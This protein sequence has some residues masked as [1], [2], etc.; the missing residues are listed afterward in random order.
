[1]PSKPVSPPP[2]VQPLQPPKLNQDTLKSLLKEHLTSLLTRGAS[3]INAHRSILNAPSLDV[4]QQLRTE[5]KLSEE[6][7]SKL[8]ELIPTQQIKTNQTSPLIFYQRSTLGLTVTPVDLCSQRN[9]QTVSLEKMA[10]QRTNQVDS[11]SSSVNSSRPSTQPGENSFFFSPNQSNR[12]LC[13][14]F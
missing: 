3:T 10:Q 8:D 4:R 6:R 13:F 9:I 14:S 11:D 5:P 2:V 12:N 7:Y 1:M